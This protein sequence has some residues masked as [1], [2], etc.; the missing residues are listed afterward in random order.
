VFV[1]ACLRECLSTGLLRRRDRGPQAEPATLPS[2]KC[3]SLEKKQSVR[4]EAG[5][6]VGMRRWRSALATVALEQEV[7]RSR[8]Q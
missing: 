6:A 7:R 4:G 8:L 1:F 2:D 5:R 3:H